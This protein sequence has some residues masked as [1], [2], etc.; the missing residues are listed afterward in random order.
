MPRDYELY[1]RDILRA[2]GSINL[3]LQEIDES[4][5]KSGDI[6]VDGILFNL[7]TIGEAVKNAG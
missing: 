2:I 6:R 3:L 5:F 1:V 7:M 4:A